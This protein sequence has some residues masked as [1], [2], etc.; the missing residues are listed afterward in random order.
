MQG[1]DT[2]TFFSR[3]AFWLLVILMITTPLSPITSF[4]SEDTTAAAGTRH[5]YEFHDGSTEY[6]ALYQGANPDMGAKVSIPR[7]ALVTDVSMTLSGASATGWSQVVS[8]TRA[9]WVAGS[10]SNVDDRS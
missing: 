2:H 9:Q 4:I 5:V 7:G 1:S 3:G 8:D 10:E 6:V